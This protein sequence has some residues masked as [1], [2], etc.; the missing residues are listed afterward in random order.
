MQV[1]YSLHQ[2]EITPPQRSINSH[3]GSRKVPRYVEGAGITVVSDHQRLKWLLTQKSPTSY[4]ISSLD[5]SSELKATYLT[6]AL[7]SFR[8][9][10]CSPIARSESE[11]DHKSHFA[12]PHHK[13]RILR[14]V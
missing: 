7:S 14:C 12:T 4:V 8:D 11:V 2:K 1:V 10:D 6:S 9:M 13:P 3:M 5:K